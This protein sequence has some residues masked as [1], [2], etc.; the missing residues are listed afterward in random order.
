MRYWEQVREEM[1]RIIEDTGLLLDDAG[2][3]AGRYAP[4]VLWETIRAEA[5]ARLY[6]KG[7]FAEGGLWTR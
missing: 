6:V 4:V 1:V 7:C 3:T 2:L 5:V